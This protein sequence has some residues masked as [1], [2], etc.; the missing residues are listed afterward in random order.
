MHTT[1]KPVLFIDFD[2]TLCHDRYW[3]SLEGEMFSTV[4]ETLFGKDNALVVEWMLGKKT[5]E[6]VNVI[7]AQKL[8]VS[9]SDL[10]K[11]FVHD[12][13]TMKVSTG[14][15]NV[16]NSL[17]ANYT[18]ILITTNMDSFTRFTVPALDLANYFDEIINSAD[19][20]LLKSDAGGHIFLN[21]IE[22]HGK[23][24][25]QSILIDDSQKTQDVFTSLGGKVLPITK[26]YSVNYY[27]ELLRREEE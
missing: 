9:F 17:R 21:A 15:L 24:I 10:W 6:E 3:K 16:I 1:P 20:S 25:T 14:T 5:A 27:L 8:N 11:L 22:K 13:E 12:C 7:L 19:K 18:V 4:Q 2:G 26:D 23:D